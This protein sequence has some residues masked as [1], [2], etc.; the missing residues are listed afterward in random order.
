MKKIYKNMD[1]LSYD[2][3]ASASSGN[4]E[5]M[6]QVLEYYDG[7][8]SHLSVREFYDEYGNR[9]SGVDETMKNVLKTKLI[10]SVLNFKPL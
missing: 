9:Y 2:I 7:Y 6:L 4:V 5:A 10:E 3:I 1:L 8:I